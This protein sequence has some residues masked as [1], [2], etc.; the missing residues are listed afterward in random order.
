[1]VTQVDQ[2]DLHVVAGLGLFEDPLGGDIGEAGGAGRADDHGDAGFG[3]HDNL[4]YAS[5][6]WKPHIGRSGRP[7]K[8]ALL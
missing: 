6:Q 5:F 3:S 2:F 7:R 4:E 8:E 1:M